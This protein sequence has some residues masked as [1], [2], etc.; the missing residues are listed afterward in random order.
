[1]IDL[2][3]ISQLLS[4]ATT[5]SFIKRYNTLFWVNWL[6]NGKSSK[7]GQIYMK[8]PVVGGGK[9]VKKF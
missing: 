2:L 7:G 5:Q 4:T 8:D 9:G 3:P 1:M 6:T